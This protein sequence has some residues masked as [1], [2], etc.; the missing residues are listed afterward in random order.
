[1]ELIPVNDISLKTFIEDKQKEILA[2][3]Q[4]N[5]EEVVKT[6]MALM[7]FELLLAV[8]TKKD[9]IEKTSQYARELRNSSWNELSLKFNG[10]YN[11]IT[12]F[13]DKF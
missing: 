7:D 8:N 1:M 2:F 3:A 6:E 12:S 5:T 9:E 10:D 11:Q 4:K 13:I